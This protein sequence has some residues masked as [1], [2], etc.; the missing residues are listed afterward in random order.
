MDDLEAKM[1]EAK[2]NDRQKK[3]VSFGIRFG[4]GKPGNEA[5]PKDF[6]PIDFGEVEK[7]VLAVKEKKNER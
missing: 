2:L 1:N 7:R 3:A 6:K 4:G 5:Q